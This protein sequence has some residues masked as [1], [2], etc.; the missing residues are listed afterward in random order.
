M[1]TD[2]D[3]IRIGSAQP[4]ITPWIL[5]E[6]LPLSEQHAATVSA[7]RAAIENVMAG[8]DKR[9]LAIVGPCSVHDPEA[10]LDF[11]TQFKAICEPL[12]DA[13]VPV[14]RVYF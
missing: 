11:A 9:V 4:L 3:D 14:L 5:A 12:Q 8:K 13:I 2:I 1:R 6:E 7:G 10:L